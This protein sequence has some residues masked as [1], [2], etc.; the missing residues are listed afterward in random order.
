MPMGRDEK[1]LQDFLDTLPAWLRRYFLGEQML[2]EDV[3]EYFKSTSAE[4]ARL[5]DV[6]WQKVQKVPRIALQVQ[7][8]RGLR[9]SVLAGFPNPRKGRPRSDEK[10]VVAAELHNKGKSYAQIAQ[11][12]GGSSESIRKLITSRRI[13]STG[14]KSD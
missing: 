4:N 7:R 11:K 3:E 10:A 12:L 1:D 14:E 9:E 2:E 5:S 6:F 13:K 8:R